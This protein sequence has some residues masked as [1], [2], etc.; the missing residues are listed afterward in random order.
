MAKLCIILINLYKKY[1]SAHTKPRCRFHPTCSTYAIESYQRFGFFIG[2]FLT[3]K[4]LL[5]CQPFYRGDPFDYVP[6]FKKD[7]FK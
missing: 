6:L 7:I 5:K 2:T 1:I 4:R 3:I